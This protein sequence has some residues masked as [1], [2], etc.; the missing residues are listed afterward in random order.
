MAAQAER[1]TWA[2]VGQAPASYAK[3]WPAGPF[4]D[5]DGPL[6][7]QA[8]RQAAQ[9]AEDPAHR[10]RPGASVTAW[11]SPSVPSSTKDV[12][13]DIELGKRWPSGLTLAKLAAVLDHRLGMYERQAEQLRPPRSSTE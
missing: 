3:R 5:R 6:M 11:R 8:A 10:S 1:R 9:L 4:S 12:V 7:Q 2:G 13:G